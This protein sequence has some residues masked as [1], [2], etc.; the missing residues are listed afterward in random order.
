MSNKKTTKKPQWGGRRE[1]SGK[2]G[3]DGGTAKICVSVTETILQNALEK[4]QGTR[5]RL[6]DHLLRGFVAEK[7][8]I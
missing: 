6:V 8:T 3:R 1:R 7:A 4:W 2:K 5:S